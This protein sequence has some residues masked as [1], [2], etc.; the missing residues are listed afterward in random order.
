M[1]KLKIR[2]HSDLENP[3]LKTR[4]AIL[5]F[6][7]ENCYAF[8]CSVKQGIWQS[9]YNNYVCYDFKPFC[10]DGFHIDI[11]I[12]SHDINSLKAFEYH[13]N[14]KMHTINYLN[15][16]WKLKSSNKLKESKVNFNIDRHFS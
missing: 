14:K 15:N 13:Y 6:I 3:I 5:E 4:E 2:I 10:P 1:K 11:L 12:T 8:G 7:N 16:C 9:K